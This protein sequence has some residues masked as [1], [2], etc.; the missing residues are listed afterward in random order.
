MVIEMRNLDETVKIFK[1]LSDPHRIRI[2]KLLEVQPLCVCEIREILGLAVSTV[3]AHLA[4]LKE[5]GL[6]FDRK[7]HRWVSYHLN[8]ATRNPMI[9]VMILYLEKQLNRDPEILEDREKIARLS[10][11]ALWDV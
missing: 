10:R 5:A 3:S 4:I 6:V 1:A 7:E 11:V 2:L 9:K 8:R